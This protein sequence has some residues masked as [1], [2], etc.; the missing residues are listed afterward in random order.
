MKS[1]LKLLLKFFFFFLLSQ[2]LEL[3]YIQECLLLS[4][5]S[6]I[7]KENIPKN[8]LESVNPAPRQDG[9]EAV[10]TYMENN[11][12]N[13]SCMQDAFDA[14]IQLFKQDATISIVGKKLIIQV[15]RKHIAN[16]IIQLKA[17]TLLA[18]LA[19]KGS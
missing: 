17:C 13:S 2:L 18:I 15:M 14:L 6:I 3:P 9:V 19:N 4:K 5:S 11:L 7:S 1:F 12:L 10:L 16:N 8:V